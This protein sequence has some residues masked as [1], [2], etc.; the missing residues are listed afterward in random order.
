MPKL[1]I[2]VCGMK[3]PANLR[4][5]AALMPDY[6]GFIFY[7]GSP[8]HMR[9]HLRP[10][11]LAALPP[12]IRTAGVFVDAELD[13]VLATAAAYG[14]GT[15]QLHGRETAAYCRQ[16]RQAG[17]EVL[18]VF[19]AGASAGWQH[20]EPYTD[21]ADAFLFDTAGPLPG[22]NGQRFDWDLLHGYPFSVPFFLSGGIGP[23][24]LEALRRFQ[25]PHWTGVDVN[26]RFEAAPGLKRTD[27]LRTW[28]R[29]LTDDSLNHT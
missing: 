2:K 29:E 3:D 7:P 27:L 19:P 21:A 20:L 1:R 25:H 24:S 12:G 8:R 11:D 28:M 10:E 9:A 18:K 4:E 6:L 22:G 16:A 15:L 5:V 23:D 14:L 26:S 17:Y 13:E